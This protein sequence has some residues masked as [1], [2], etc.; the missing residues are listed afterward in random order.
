MKTCN[1]CGETKPIEEFSRRHTVKD[2]RRSQ[3]K[4]CTRAHGVAWNAANKQRKAETNRNMREGQKTERR[5]KLEKIEQEAF[6][7]GYKA[8]FVD[9]KKVGAAG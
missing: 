7:R 5:T 3:C 8:G 2:G 4:T 1:K 6:D 9:G